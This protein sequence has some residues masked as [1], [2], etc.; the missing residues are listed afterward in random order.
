MENKGGT[1][2]KGLPEAKVE[3]LTAEAIM[4]NSSRT[5]L[6]WFEWRLSQAEMGMR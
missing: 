6:F 4:K 1:E 2:K 5:F 3:S